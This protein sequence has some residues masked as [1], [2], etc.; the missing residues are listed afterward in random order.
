MIR[1]ERRSSS[2]TEIFE[3]CF[4]SIQSAACERG[5]GEAKVNQRDLTF[6]QRTGRSLGRLLSACN[7]EAH[8]S[9]RSTTKE[10]LKTL[11]GQ[12]CDHKRDTVHRKSDT[13][14]HTD[15]RAHSW[16]EGISS[17][18][19]KLCLSVEAPAARRSHPFALRHSPIKTNSLCDGQSHGSMLI[20]RPMKSV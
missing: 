5:I 13:Y 20:R 10:K 16:Q 9:R 17:S 18:V 12:Q 11:S 7:V 8:V 1:D 4:T 14:T 6:T 19:V 3:L 2:K 15:K